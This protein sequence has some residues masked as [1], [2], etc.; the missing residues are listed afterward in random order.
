MEA[1]HSGSILPVVRIAAL[2]AGAGAGADNAT[3]REDCWKRL[4][5]EGALARGAVGEAREFE[6]GGGVKLVMGYVP[7]GTFIMGSPVGEEGR[8][9]NETPHEVILTSHCWMGETEV[10]QAQ[11]EAVMGGNPSYFKGERL[12]VENVSWEDADALVKK[13]NQKAPL[14]GGWRWALPSEAQWERACRGGT[15]TAFHYGD[16]L[17]ST[18]VNFD[19]KYPYGGATEGPSLQKTAPVK[20]YLPNAYGLYDMHGNGL[21]WCVDWYGDYPLGAAKDTRGATSGSRRVFRGGSWYDG[22]GGCASAF[23][24]GS[25]PANRN[26]F[27]GFRVV[28]APG[29]AER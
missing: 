24:Y 7:G 8:E 5:A 18:Q 4:L 26:N 16:S 25:G 22:S 3:L 27:C 20:S 17:S 13:L 2:C 11:W 14:P 6:V 19:R 23:R 10:T 29:P 15:G 1:F 12:P 21:E 28:L 9:D